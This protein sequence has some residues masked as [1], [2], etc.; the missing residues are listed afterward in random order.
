MHGVQM[1]SNNLWSHDKSIA[2][3]KK[4]NYSFLTK[5]PTE[6]L[7]FLNKSRQR[8]DKSVIQIYFYVCVSNYLSMYIYI[9]IYIYIYI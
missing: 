1:E 5:V 6:I 8:E 3:N 9:H 7:T 4:T 2:H